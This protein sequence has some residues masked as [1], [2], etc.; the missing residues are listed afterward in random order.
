LN[1]LDIQLC[2]IP[3]DLLV[4]CFDQATFK[5]SSAARAIL[6]AGT[7]SSEV[8]AFLAL[9]ILDWIVVASGISYIRTKSEGK[10]ERACVHESE[11]ETADGE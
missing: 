2:R 3:L 5:L 10:R 4:P 8:H 7:S 9:S 6:I 11:R 1:D